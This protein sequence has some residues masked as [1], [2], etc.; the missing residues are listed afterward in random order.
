MKGH[1]SLTALWLAP[2]ITL[3]AA[4]TLGHPPS[5]VSNR[6]KLIEVAEVIMPWP[7]Y[8]D[9]GN[10]IKGQYSA[11]HGGSVCSTELELTPTP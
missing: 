9:C 1:I 7:V 6:Y 8:S 2:P 3:L 11:I 5:F 4:A 10:G